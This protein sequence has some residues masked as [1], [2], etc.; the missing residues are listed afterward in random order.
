MRKLR[1]LCVGAG[2]FSQYQYEAWSR[3]PEV[4]ILAVVNRSLERARE[5]AARFNL[6][7]AAGWEELPALLESAKPDFIDV[8]TPPE[9]HL[10]IVRLAAARG[11]AIICQKPLAPTWEEAVAVVDT[12][13]RAGLRFLVH[14]NWRWQPWY[15]EMKRQ[16]DAGALGELFSIAVRMRMG[17][18]WPAD[19]YLARQ[20]FFR[21]YPRLLVYETGVHF[22]DTFR[23][24]GGE[25]ASVYAR[26][27]KRNA[28]I[29][30][31][32]AG[33]IVCGFASGA[34]AIL[35]ASRYNETDTAD[36]RYTFGS[37]RLDGSRG[38]LE[39]D[40]DGNLTL[41][42]L[43]QPSRR[44]EYAPERK[45]FAGDC[46]YHLQRHFTACMLTGA[47]FESTGEDYLK[48]V[49]LVEA[50]YRSHATGQVVSPGSALVPPA[51]LFH[52][53]DH[54]AIAVSDT[55]EALKIWRDTFGFTLLYAEDVNN[56]TV[57]LTH[58]DLGNTHLQLVQP[59]T[60]DHPIQGW[61]KQHGAGLHHLCLRVDNVGDA[62]RL[63]P[64]FQLPTAP[65]VHQGTRGKRALFLEKSAT[66]GVQVEVTGA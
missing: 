21:S 24:L 47:P 26:L 5:T 49:A 59:L 45:G 6:P 60:A 37:V 46:V 48:S 55:D 4:E 19:A 31:E 51:T 61:L 53:L 52:G 33:Q 11:I 1:G 30:G 14:E 36:A 50:C 40:T 7:H 15:R 39:L 23:F 62:L 25:V 13:K 65:V 38:H 28:A 27:Q 42:P 12:A 16:L 9:T 56:G 58:L 35:D 64:K 10:E 20:P 54:F 34:T 17:D 41:K 18:G 66:Q 3:M 2:Y 63:L 8:I 32:D 44:L 43:G 29:A 22:L 57:R